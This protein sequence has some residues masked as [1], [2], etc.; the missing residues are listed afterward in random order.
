MAYVANEGAMSKALR[1]VGLGDRMV[2]A[3]FDSGAGRSYIVRGAIPLGAVE[4]RDQ[5]AREVGLGGRGHRIQEWRTLVVEAD[6]CDFS[7]KAYVLDEIGVEEGRPIELIIGAPALEEWQIGI[8]P[9][10]R[11]LVPDLSRLRGGSF[12]DFFGTSLGG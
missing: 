4:G 9:E 7:F 1:E 11:R 2:W 8:R 10:G 12:V 3:L 6:G 5:T